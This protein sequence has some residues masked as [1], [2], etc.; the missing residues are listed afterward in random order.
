L[1]VT[2]VLEKPVAEKPRFP[3]ESLLSARLLL[4]PESVYDRVF[5]LSDM[6]GVLSLYSMSKNGGIPEPLLPG[7]LALVN[8]HLIPGDNYHVVPKMGKILVMIDKMGNENYQPS[9]IPMTGGIPEPLLG[10]K[11]QN[12]QIACVH[13]DKERDIAYFFRDNRKTPDIECLKVNLETREVVSLGTSVYGNVCNGVSSDHSTVILADQYTA[14]DVVLYYRKAGMNDRKLLYGSPLEER[15][16]K[17]VPFSGIGWCSFVDNDKG[18]FFPSTIFH[19]AGGLTYLKLDNPSQPIDVPAKGLQHSGQ[20][21][22]IGLRKVEADLFVLEYNID[23]ASWIYE[24]TFHSGPSPV[25]EAR[26]V[27]VGT[28]PL[29]GGVVL[30]LEWQVTN[31][32]P[33]QIEYVLS[34]T[35]ANNPSQ[36]YSILG[37]S[38]VQPTRLSNEK[39]LGIPEEYLSPGEDVSY[40]SFDGLRISARLYLPSPNLGFMGPRPLV[41]YVHGGPQGQERPDFTWFSMPLIQYLTL[42]GFAVFVPNVRGSTGYGMKY[43][44]WVD[45]DW[46][47]KDVLD[48]IEGL[49][50]LEKDSRIDSKRRGVV[51]RSYGGYMTLTLASRHP[52]LWKAA[53]DMFGPYDLP[54]WLARLPPTWQTYFRLSLGDPEK[55]K[56]FLV[57]RSPKTYMSQLSS[58]LMIIQGKHDPRVPEPESAQLVSDLRKDGVNIDYLVYEDEGHDVLR[59]KNRVHCYNTI[60]EFFRKNLAS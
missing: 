2:E 34:F 10:D 45:R 27:L 32:N 44:K 8:P 23:G 7:G 50:R 24:G 16:D 33:L 37:K 28:S 38:N 5:F 29:S 58:P 12:E 51:G 41:E 20:G 54:T 14:G 11:Y 56:D 6:S 36:L 3:I 15:E 31:H 35:K 46:G 21:E 48:H 52:E 60:T 30:G 9:L 13:F 59:F 25:F 53:V 18:L 4:K 40:N 57:E 42:N 47:G 55:D 17:Q 1:T 22:L 39:V 19:D 26:R 49:K 43:T